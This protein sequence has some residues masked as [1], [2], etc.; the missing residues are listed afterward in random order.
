MQPRFRLQCRNSIARSVP[1]MRVGVRIGLDLGSKRIGVARCDRDGLIAIPLTAFDAAG[2]WHDALR[3]L[4]DEVDAIEI[5]VGIPVS[6]RG[7][8]ERAA[9]DVRDRIAELKAAFPGLPIRGVDERMSSA[10]ANR[11]LREAGHSSKSARE[12]VDA[13]A[14]AGILE[15]ALETERRTGEPAGELV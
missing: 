8:E 15:F 9:L 6:L 12:H 5:V 4:L 7:A 2:S 11:Q 13:L 14:A 3:A 1:D 10:V